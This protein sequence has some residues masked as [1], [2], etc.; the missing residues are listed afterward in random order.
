MRTSFRHQSEAQPPN[1]PLTAATSPD[2][3]SICPATQSGLCGAFIP[4]MGWMDCGAPISGSTPDGTLIL[5]VGIQSHGQGLE[6][7]LA[8][9]AHQILGIDPAQHFSPAWRYRGVAI[10]HGYHCVAQHGDGRRRCGARYQAIAGEGTQ[11]WGPS[12]ANGSRRRSIRGRPRCEST[13][14]HKHRR[15]R[16][17]RAS[18]SPLAVSCHVF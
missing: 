8:Q 4:F 17:N 14:K 12:S 5:L 10:R 7:T 2:T 6:T 15:D 11:D 3:P 1:G 9:V 18:S 16:A 13:R